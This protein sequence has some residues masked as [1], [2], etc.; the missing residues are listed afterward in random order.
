MKPKTKEEIAAMKVQ[1]EPFVTEFV[2]HRDASIAAM[3]K[4]ARPT[5]RRGEK[6]ESLEYAQDL[7]SGDLLSATMTVEQT[8]DFLLKDWVN[9]HG[10]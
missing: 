6:H 4:A 2:K 1:I 9:P 3:H 10:Y 7:C 5:M 8:I